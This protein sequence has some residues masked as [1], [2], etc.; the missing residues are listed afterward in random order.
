MADDK[1]NSGYDL[2][3]IARPKSVIHPALDWVNGQLVVGVV[4]E[5]GHRAALTSKDGLVE[6]EKIGVVCERDG[7]FNSPVTPEMAKE[8]V[9][10]L[11]SNPTTCPTEELNA[12]LIELAE[13][14]RRFVIFPWKHWA[15]VM[16]TWTLGTY[17][18][19][20][21]QAYPYLW[22]TSPEPGCGKSLL[23]QILANL[24]FN[25]EFMSSPTEA[26]MFHLP[27]QNRGVQVWDEV[28]LAN[29]IEK[30]KF[31]SVKA[32]LLVGYRNGSTV[33]RQVGKNWDKQ[34]KYHV[35]CPRVVI[36]LS[37]LPETAQQRSIELRLRKRKPGQEAE[38]YRIHDHLEQ[39]AHLRAKCVLT[40]L[41]CASGINQSYRDDPLR[42]NIEALLG[43]AGREVDDIWLPLFAIVS[44]CSTE[45]KIDPTQNSLMGDLAKA[46]VQLAEFRDNPLLAGAAESPIAASQDRS[47]GTEVEEP[48]ETLMAA[49]DIVAWGHPMEPTDLAERVSKRMNTEVSTQWLSKS[50]KCLGIRAKK[51]GKGSRRVF[52]VLPAELRRAEARLGVEAPQSR[53]ESGQQGQEGQQRPIVISSEELVSTE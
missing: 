44:A 8:F 10:Y 5:N 53:C 7:N 14:F 18:F 19:P 40:A 48:D 31:Q 23:G 25:G 1:K 41:K 30:S 28:E 2:D 33:P 36:G 17:L 6:I 21:F 26:N 45:T 4:F 42:K 15:S 9:A 38:I 20:V 13:Y 51:Q 49:L 27:E 43:K 12:L 52:N 39:E 32:I 11:E 29:Q 22:L 46:A 34:V 3:K 47:A 37:R 16:A 50:L 24:S 35:Y